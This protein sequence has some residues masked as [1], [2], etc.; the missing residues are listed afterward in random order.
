MYTCVNQR[1]ILYGVVF[2]P[3]VVDQVTIIHKSI[4]INI[5]CN[6][7]LSNEYKNTH[8]REFC[9]LTEILIKAR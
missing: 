1:V 5:L 3:W 2:S 8:T 6:I 4:I 9:L 7:L